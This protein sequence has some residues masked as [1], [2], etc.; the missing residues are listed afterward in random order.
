MQQSTVAV[1]FF[2]QVE[3]DDLI[4]K[5]MTRQYPD[6]SKNGVIKEIGSFEGSLTVA[7][8][9]G[10]MLYIG[11]KSI[12]SIS[13]EGSKSNPRWIILSGETTYTIC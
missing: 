10:R 12:T 7:L 2:D 4:G 5:T 6:G 13:N 1:D 8:T 9:D 11:A 3:N